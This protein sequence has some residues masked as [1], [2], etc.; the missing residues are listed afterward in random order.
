L[1]IY[2]YNGIWFLCE[3]QI[4]CGGEIVN[5]KVILSALLHDVGKLIQRTQT[6]E[7]G[8][9][10][11][12]GCDFIKN[13]TNDKDILN[14]VLLHHKSQIENAK[15]EA[16]SISYI[17]YISDN[18]SAGADRRESEAEGVNHFNRS[19][20]LS[21]IFNL[22]NNNNGNLTYRLTDIQ[23]MNMPRINENVTCSDYNSLLARF[24]DGMHGIEFTTDYINSLME[25]IEATFSYIP[26]STNTGQ[27]SDISLY[28]HSKT[29]A[30]I[31]S[32]IYEYLYS[33]N[34]NDYKSILF[35]NEKEF[36]NEKAFLMFSFDFSGIQKFIYT[37]SSENALKMLRAR[38]FYLEML[39]EHLVDRLLEKCGLSRANLIYS[40]GGHCYIL[41][42]NTS[43]TKEVIY[44]FSFTVNKWLLGRFGDLLYVATGSTECSA[45]DL[46]NIGSTD[47]SSSYKDIFYRLSR[48]LA[49]SKLKRYSADD[50][51]S[52]NNMS[53]GEMIRECRVCG[54]VRKLDPNQKMCDFCSKLI[55]I[56][57]ELVKEKRVLYVTQEK[58]EGAINLDLPLLNGETAYLNCAG[59]QDIIN[60]QKE[61]KHLILSTYGINE[62]Y[63]GIN[64]YSKLWMGS[65]FSRGDD[66][67]MLTFEELA[68]CSH[69]IR[70]IGVLRADVDFLGKAFIEGFERKDSRD[71]YKYV[72]LSRYSTLSRYL[73]LFFKK[74]INE[75]LSSDFKESRFYLTK[76][77]TQKGNRDKKVTIVYSG[78]DDLFIVGAWNEVLEAAVDIRSVFQKYT[79]S[80]LT[81]SAGFGI[82]DKSFPVSRMAE[83]TA[84]LE[85]RA[86]CNDEKK[87]SISLF[88]EQITPCENGSIR[89]DHTYKWDVFINNVIGEKLRAIQDY[90]E[91]IKILESAIG[92]AFLYRLM[93]FI[94][95]A[96]NKINIAR[97]AY[98]LGRLTPNEKA[99]E[100]EKR[101]YSIFSQNIYRW[102]L[103]EADR[104]QL[105]TA[106]N[107]Y[108]Y[109]NRNKEED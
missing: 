23:K 53:S 89:F 38:S 86:K 85:S 42:P 99:S 37:I 33:Y 62:L 76:E 26:S 80:T 35:F 17:I 71:R 39:V 32:C 83:I 4:I 27:V 50:I 2:A 5:T 13:Y 74:H 9:H 93:N 43:K 61:Y 29:T 47:T 70:K 48:S 55:R 19:M 67:K 72:S 66:G 64:Y 56:S 82:F 102:I 45:N 11:R 75:I 22:L 108:I 109:L 25:L 30:A 57:S 101:A 60:I 73:S 96:E 97:C 103:N 77:K 14:S 49:S 107:I 59:Y 10:Y 91:T 3:L 18:I 98:L 90:F 16:N 24:K 105:L 69:G 65:F 54:E 94:V 6:Q 7:G 15:I 106:I 46:M 40:G 84:M 79:G 52:I 104:K 41:L 58:T 31:A 44:N 12:C 68:K 21:S 87:D 1:G 34:K 81:F 51:R 88:G 36:Y 92:N 78:G 20:P 63:T 95:G 100:V 28:D 8:T